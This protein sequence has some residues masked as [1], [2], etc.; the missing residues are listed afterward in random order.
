VSTLRPLGPEAAPHCSHLHLCRGAP[1][2]VRTDELNIE[3]VLI[4]QETSLQWS[5]RSLPQRAAPTCTPGFGLETRLLLLVVGGSGCQL[6]VSP[7][8]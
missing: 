1:H 4:T 7:G 8:V 5:I 2:P 6:P 3:L